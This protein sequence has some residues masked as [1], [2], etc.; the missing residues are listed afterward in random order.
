MRGERAG[1]NSVGGP[2]SCW[3]A[4]AE[5]LSKCME[6]LHRVERDRVGRPEMEIGSRTGFRPCQYGTT[7]PDSEIAW[8]ALRI[9]KILCAGGFTHVSPDRVSGHDGVATVGH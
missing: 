3:D 7:G 4:C 9:G 1:E 2:T 5:D 6:N 8:I